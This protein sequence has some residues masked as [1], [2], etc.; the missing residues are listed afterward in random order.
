MFLLQA[1]MREHECT[2]TTENSVVTVTPATKECINAGNLTTRGCSGLMP[3]SASSNLQGPSSSRR[4]RG[5]G[6]QGPPPSGS[7][8]NYKNWMAILPTFRRRWEPVPL[9]LHG[10]GCTRQKED[11]SSAY[12]PHQGLL[13]QGQRLHIFWVSFYRTRVRSLAM[14][15]TH[16][17]PNSL[18]FSKL[19]WCDPGVWRCLLTRWPNGLLAF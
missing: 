11:W 3:S 17:L 5:A 15:V 14:L 1:Y 13:L 7:S 16:W 6:G 18:L 4:K 2:L 9:L 10:H 19:D 8:S 12:R